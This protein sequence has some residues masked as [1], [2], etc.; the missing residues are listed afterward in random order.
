MAEAAQTTGN[1]STSHYGERNP[2]VGIPFHLHICVD[3]W[4]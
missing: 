4:V 3:P 1:T 2:V